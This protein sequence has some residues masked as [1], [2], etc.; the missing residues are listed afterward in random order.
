MTFLSKPLWIISGILMMLCSSFTSAQPY[1]SNFGPYRPYYP[2]NSYSMPYW[3]QGQ[4]MFEPPPPPPNGGYMSPP[5]NWNDPPGG[6]FRPMPPDGWDFYSE[7]MIPPPH[8]P[9]FRWGPPNPYTG[10]YGAGPW[11]MQQWGP[12][13]T[14]FMPPPYIGAYPGPMSPEGYFVPYPG[15]VPNFSQRQFQQSSICH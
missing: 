15:F 1:S 3:Y 5:K 4:R 14:A 12:S 11:T 7:R 8:Y 13:R 2:Y 9:N 6:Y 10:G